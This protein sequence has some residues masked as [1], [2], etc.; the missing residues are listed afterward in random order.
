MK[1]RGKLVRVKAW[2]VVR[3]DGCLYRVWPEDQRKAAE[4]WCYYGEHLLPCIV[5]YRRPA[6][7]KR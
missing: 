7:R 6:R 2:A 5:S 1:K 3:S 4:G